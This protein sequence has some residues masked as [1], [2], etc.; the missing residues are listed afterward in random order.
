[1]GRGPE[2]RDQPGAYHERASGGVRVR[3]SD[4]LAR[5]AWS[6]SIETRTRVTATRDAFRV[7]AELR[8]REGDREVFARRFDESVTRRGV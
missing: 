1:M 5:G 8:A 7:E 4:P 6:V 3:E 2:A